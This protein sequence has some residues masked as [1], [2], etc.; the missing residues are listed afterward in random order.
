MRRRRLLI[1][2]FGL[3]V[4]NVAAAADLVPSGVDGYR[5]KVLRRGRDIGR[6]TV[7]LQQTGDRLLVVTEIDLAVRIAFVTA[8]RFGHSSNEIWENGR[9]TGL[10]GNTNENGTRFRVSGQPGPAGF[11]VEGPAGPTVVS[12]DMLTSNTLW[13]PRF[14]ERSTLINAQQGGEIG[15]SAVAEGQDSITVRGRTVATRRYNIVTP[16]GAGQIWYDSADHWVQARLEADGE[17]VD[18]EL[19]S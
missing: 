13:S 11:R 16:L 8:F 14:V 15:L 19:E 3:L 17:R 18:Y 4:G 10:S 1:G 2:S 9:L 6:H 5:F 7:D 12:D